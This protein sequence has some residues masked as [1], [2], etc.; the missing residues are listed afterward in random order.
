MQ[1]LGRILISSLT[2]R[3][4]RE[5]SRRPCWPPNHSLR[6]CSCSCPA[7]YDGQSEAV[8]VVDA[9]A[10]ES[11]EGVEE[12]VD[13]LGRDHRPGVRDGEGGVAAPTQAWYARSAAVRPSSAM[14]S[15]VP[16]LSRA[17]RRWRRASVV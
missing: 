13:L 3:I 7:S 16:A 11:L 4:H 2:G 12:A 1:V 17:T 5:P 15:V 10:V 9:G 8:L 6:L 14:P